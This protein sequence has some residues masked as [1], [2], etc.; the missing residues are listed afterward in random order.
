MSGLS[1]FW[2][3]FYILGIVAG[4]DSAAVKL[5]CNKHIV[6]GYKNLNVYVTLCFRK[7]DLGIV[8][9]LNI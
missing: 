2:T 1:C 4:M 9:I 5:T 3:I 8:T 7:E 6:H